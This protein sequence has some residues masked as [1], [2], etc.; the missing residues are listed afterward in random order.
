MINVAHLTTS[1]MS[2][3]TSLDNER[4]NDFN[5][6]ENYHRSQKERAHQI[7]Q[8]MNAVNKTLGAVQRVTD[9]IASAHT[10]TL[11]DAMSATLNE[12]VASVDMQAI[13]Q[14]LYTAS[15]DRIINHTLS[16]FDKTMDKVDM[17]EK[18]SGGVLA[19]L[20]EALN[21]WR[22]RGVE[23]EEHSEQHWYN[24]GRYPLV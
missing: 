13:N 4:F 22:N 10:T 11:M 19:L 2:N 24:G 5:V 20:T 15:D 12:K 21:A 14:L 6:D 3:A 8:R 16:L 1:V 7:E 23:H 18:T 9:M 17:Y